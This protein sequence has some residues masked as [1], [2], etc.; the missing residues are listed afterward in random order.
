MSIFYKYLYQNKKITIFTLLNVDKCNNMAKIAYK[1]FRELKS[2]EIT[3]LFINKSR[4]L[5]YDKWL[6]SSCYPTKGFAVRA[7][8]HCTESPNAPHLSMKLKSGEIRVWKK[9]LI[10]DYK[11][12]K[13]P[14]NQGGLWFLAKKMKI[15]ND[16]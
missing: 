11:E 1:L 16:K 6:D 4:K 10:E 12:F 7:G 3:S 8:W 5:P 14:E 13:R 9:V 2:G 15:I